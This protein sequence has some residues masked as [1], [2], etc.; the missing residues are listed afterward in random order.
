MEEI[1][2]RCIENIW[3]V[4]SRQHV[5]MTDHYVFELERSREDELFSSEKKFIQVTSDSL[6]FRLS[7]TFFFEQ[8]RNFSTI[9]GSL[10]QKSVESTVSTTV[11]RQSSRANPPKIIIRRPSNSSLDKQSTVARKISKSRKKGHR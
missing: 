10:R 9:E 6:K 2:I 7:D 3:S 5:H 11:V 8:R 1:S 4:K